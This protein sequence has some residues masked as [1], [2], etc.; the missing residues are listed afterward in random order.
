M[1][2]LLLMMITMS[3]VAVVVA[4]RLNPAH[5]RKLKTWQTRDTRRGDNIV[6]LNELVDRCFGIHIYEYLLDLVVVVP[7]SDRCGI[8][9]T[10]Y[11]P[12]RMV[13]VV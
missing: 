13:R 6:I 5:V 9:V 3:L 10:V 11:D 4:R 7:M 2:L 8:C 12:R 1:L